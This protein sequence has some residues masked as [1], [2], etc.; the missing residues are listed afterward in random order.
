MNHFDDPVLWCAV[1]IALACF[2]GAG[3]VHGLLR[4]WR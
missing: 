4:E 3:F 2:I 1:C